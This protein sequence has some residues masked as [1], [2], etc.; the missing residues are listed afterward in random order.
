MT[1]VVAVAPAPAVVVGVRSGCEFALVVVEL[2]F[3]VVVPAGAVLVGVGVL[4]LDLP[5]PSWTTKYAAR[6]STELRLPTRVVEVYEVVCT[7][8]AAV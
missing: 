1:A 3:E 7:L 5:P 6:Y 4:L 8:L 2:G